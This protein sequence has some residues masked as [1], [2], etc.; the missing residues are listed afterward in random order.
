MV[1]DNRQAEV[2]LLPGTIMVTSPDH[3]GEAG[4]PLSHCFVKFKI[5]VYP[6]AYLEKHKK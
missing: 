1:L 6:S 4:L 5:L 3:N 2:S